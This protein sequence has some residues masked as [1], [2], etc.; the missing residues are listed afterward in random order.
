M[1]WP[2]ILLHIESGMAFDEALEYTKQLCTLRLK[3]LNDSKKAK[4]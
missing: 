2:L 1:G 4:V 3:I